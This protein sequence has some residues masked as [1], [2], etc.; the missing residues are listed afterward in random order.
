MWC[1]WVRCSELS[2][3]PKAFR[4]PCKWPLLHFQ[5]I[6]ATGC[7]Q[8]LL[9]CNPGKPR[10]AA[11]QVWV[12][13]RVLQEDV[14]ERSSSDHR[15]CLLDALG[16]QIQTSGGRL[17]PRV[18]PTKG[19]PNITLQ[20]YSKYLFSQYNLDIYTNQGV[21]LDGLGGG[22]DI[23]GG[24]ERCLSYQA[25]PGVASSNLQEEE[26]KAERWGAE[27]AGGVEGLGRGQ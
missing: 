27:V 4:K 21:A 26:V 9:C 16:T 5:P 6:T 23:L 7:L 17:E 13:G 19:Q 14:E 1:I 3:L 8:P 12:Q 20:M 2:A 22:G 18:K 24:C 25:T 10:G 15:P 11:V